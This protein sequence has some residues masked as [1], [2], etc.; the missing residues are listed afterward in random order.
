MMLLYK[1]MMYTKFKK[2]GFTLIELLV[3]VAIISLLASVVLA[4]LS[5]VR[6]KANDK[7]RMADLRS[8]QVALDL[9]LDDNGRYPA[10]NWCDSSIGSAGI[11]CTDMIAAGNVGS[12]WDTNSIFYSQFIGS[13]VMSELPVDPINNGTYYYYYEPT[14]ASEGPGLGQGYFVRTRLEET[15]QLWGICSGLTASWCN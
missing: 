9:Y 12:G 13:G 5:D 1:D 7:K 8:M 3:V 11:R 10:E 2:Q 6:V 14:N 15:G 4:S